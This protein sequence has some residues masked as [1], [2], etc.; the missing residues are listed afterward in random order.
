MAPAGVPHRPKW[1]RT[2]GEKK[3]FKPWSPFPSLSGSGAVVLRQGGDLAQSR[4]FLLS[5]ERTRELHPAPA[6]S[7]EG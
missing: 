5:A 4:D 3:E 2:S 6:F 1:S 7:L